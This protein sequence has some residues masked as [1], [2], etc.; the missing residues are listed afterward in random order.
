M[1]TGKAGRAYP[2]KFQLTDASGN[3]VSAPSAVKSVTYQSTACGS[4]GGGTGTPQPAATSGNSGL[5]YDATANQ[6]VYVWQTPSAPGCYTLTL[7]LD[8]GQTFQA[9]FNLS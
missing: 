6:Y 8:S 2:L 3:Y 7:T 9:Y 1:N 4:F 5:Q